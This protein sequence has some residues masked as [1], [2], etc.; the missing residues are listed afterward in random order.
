MIALL[1][2]AVYSLIM[3]EQLLYLVDSYDY[4]HIFYFVLMIQLDS[5]LS[6]SL[7]LSPLPMAIMM[8]GNH[9]TEIYGQ[10]LFL[11]L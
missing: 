8:V 3:Q 1:L 9:F 5:S 2:L 11:L 7:S 6:L 4:N 10:N